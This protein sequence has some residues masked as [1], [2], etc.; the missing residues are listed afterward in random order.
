MLFHV[1][2]Q[3]RLP[4]TLESSTVER[5]KESEMSMAQALQRNGEWRHL[6]RLA[7]CYANVSIFD[8]E[9]PARLHDIL[10][11]LPL[12]PYMEITVRALCQHPSSILGEDGRPVEGAE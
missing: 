5:L 12:F 11:K 10:T 2:M 8:V 4:H 7:G 9:S 6:W 3:V 1:E